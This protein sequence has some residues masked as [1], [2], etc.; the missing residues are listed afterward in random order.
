MSEIELD[1]G[2]GEG[3]INFSFGRSPVPE[4]QP[5]AQPPVELPAAPRWAFDEKK[6][7]K[8]IEPA[9]QI[10]ACRRGLSIPRRAGSRPEIVLS[11]EL[12]HVAAD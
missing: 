10:S 11:P 3:P 6:L 1:D 5:R 8:L 7:R 4:V 12:S 2:N 9:E